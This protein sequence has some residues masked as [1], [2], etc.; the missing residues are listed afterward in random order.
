MKDYIKG[1]SEC[2]AMIRQSGMN[3]TIL[4]PWYVLGPGHRWPYLLVPFYKLMELIPQ[5]RQGATRLGLV[6]LEQMT[7]ALLCAVENPPPNVRI[8]EVPEIRSP[9]GVQTA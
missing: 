1:R 6:T 8:V 5:T 2:E 7:Q 3:A 9:G 4:R